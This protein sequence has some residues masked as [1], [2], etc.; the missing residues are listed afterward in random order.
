MA[1]GV[2]SFSKTFVWIILA[3]LIV[4]LAGFGATNLSGTVRSVGHAGDQ[5]I[6]VDAYARE[7]QREIRALEAQAG[8]RVPMSQVQAMGLDRTVLARLVAI[9]SLDHEVAEMGLSIGDA[10]LQ[11]EI[12]KVPAFQGIDGKFDRESY[13]FALNQAGLSE[14]EFEAELRAEN[15][16]T[17]VQGAIVSGATMPDV[18]ATTLADFIAARRSF[19]WATVTA[20]NLPEPVPAPTP[21]E[22]RTFYDANPDRFSLPETKRLTYVLLTPDMILDQVEVDAAALRTLYD[23]RSDE[24]DLPERRLVER[25]VFANAAAADRA[26]AQLD[27]AG[28]T[29]E[30]LVD[31][32]GLSLADIDLGDVTRDDLD[33]AAEAVFAADIGQTV[34]PLPSPLGPALFRINGVLEARTTAFEE[35]EDELRAELAGDRARRLIETGAGDIDDL[36]AAGATLEELANETDMQLGRIDWTAEATGDVAAYESFRAAAAAVTEADFPAVTYMD[37]GGIF[38][39]RLDEVLPVRPEPFDT[40]RDKVA[41]AWTR[42]QT[43]EALQAH[44]E[45]LVQTLGESGDF[46]ETGLSV[47]VENGLTRTAYL[48]GTPADFMARVFEMDK[49]DVQVISGEDSVMIVR[50]EDMRPPADTPEL[51][52][53]RQALTERL[54]QS[55]SEALF[56]AYVSDVQSRAKPQIDQRALNAVQ[57]SFQ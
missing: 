10:N 15:A 42:A 49:G 35:V 25:L 13:R 47:R 53:M 39:L 6:S 2:K 20:D 51:T 48:E 17:L 19:T 34:G 33:D 38:A 3:L 21:E 43:V 12:L 7:L 16:R 52:E 45:T 8:E 27:V 1:A 50:L 31:D 4:G 28:T 57:A 14:A 23:S 56:R 54:N 29:F 11:Q 55:L 24:F 9:A 44:A 26:K 22:L 30:A 46:A 32:R 36:L 5:V 37:E 18:M 41:E 40:A